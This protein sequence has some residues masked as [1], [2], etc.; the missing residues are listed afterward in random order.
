ML[1]K[2]DIGA[3]LA[4]RYVL[5]TDRMPERIFEASRSEDQL[6]AAAKRMLDRH[7]L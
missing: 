1:T 7:E 5:G 3:S 2:A 6:N 4:R